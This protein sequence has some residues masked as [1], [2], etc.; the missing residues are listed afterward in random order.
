MA[1]S[2]VNRRDPS[3]TRRIE[4]E[5][6]A[7]QRAIISAYTEAMAQVATGE[8]PDRVARLE[9]LSDAL[10]DELAEE[11]D[12]W[13]KKT[14]EAS[15]AN[16]Q[17]ILNNMHTG[18]ELGNTLYIPRAE[19]EML[20]ANILTNVRSIGGDLLKQVTQITADGY[21]QGL[22][23]AQIVRNIQEAGDK[24]VRH[25]E[26]I[27]RTE[28]MRVADVSLKAKWDETSCD[29]YVSFPVDDDRLCPECVR[30]AVGNGGTTL[31]VYRRDEPMALPWHPNCR[32][33]RLPHFPGKDVTL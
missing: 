24:Q 23:V 15:V 6:I 10:K 5:E 22:G 19:V 27:V 17:R 20:K 3:G 28:T 2:Y 21:Q 9:R 25:A 12:S 7:R 18:I 1:R 11:A 26:T 33:I 13:M 29:G 8:D 4:R 14:E 30:R 32:C 31:R 16:S